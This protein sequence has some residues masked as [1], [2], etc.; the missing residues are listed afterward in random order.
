MENPFRLTV[1]RAAFGVL[2][3]PAGGLLSGAAPAEEP[4][5]KALLADYRSLA[6]APEGSRVHERTVQLGHLGLYFEDGSLFPLRSSGGTT[7]GLFFRGRGRYTYHAADPGDRQ[8]LAESLSHRTVTPSLQ[9]SAVTDPFGQMV[10][11]FATPVFQEL[12]TANSG[13]EASSA[14]APA[15]TRRSRWDRKTGRRSKSSGGAFKR[16]TCLTTTSRPRRG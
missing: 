3:L 4:S 13:E 16:P 12:W 7:L 10:I 2:L 8:A 1:L 14:T 9:N 11:F 6:P 15:P 5:L